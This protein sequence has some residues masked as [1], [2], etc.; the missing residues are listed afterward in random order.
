MI[1]LNTILL[2]TY[3]ILVIFLGGIAIIGIFLPVKPLTKVFTLIASPVA[4]ALVLFLVME[5]IPNL[6]EKTI[7]GI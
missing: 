2:M 3:C 7:L 1:F 5:W 6:Y 4:L